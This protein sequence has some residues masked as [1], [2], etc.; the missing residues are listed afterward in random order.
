MYVLYLLREQ[1]LMGVTSQ[2]QSEFSCQN[3]EGAGRCGRGLALPCRALGEGARAD[4]RPGAHGGSLPAWETDRS[5]QWP[6][7]I[8]ASLCPRDVASC[9]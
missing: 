3:T 1:S 7:V 6:H 5:T 8:R 4:T 2:S 9:L